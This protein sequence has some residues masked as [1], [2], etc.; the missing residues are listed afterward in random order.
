MEDKGPRET[1]GRFKYNYQYDARLASVSRTTQYQVK[2][3]QWSWI[4]KSI[5]SDG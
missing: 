5:P 2:I 1:G 3:I 4:G